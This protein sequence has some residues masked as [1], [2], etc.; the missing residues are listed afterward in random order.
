MIRWILGGTG[1]LIVLFAGAT[2]AAGVDVSQTA[3]AQ[4][5]GGGGLLMPVAA[6]A[7]SQGFGCTPYAFEPANPA[8][9]SGH[10]HSGIDLTSAAGMPVHATLGGVATVTAS[11]L[12][13]GLHVVVDHGG[14]LSSLYGHLSEVD[15]V[16]GA[17]V[18]AGAVIGRVGS[19]GNSTGPHLH[20]EIRRD[21]I[22]EDPAIDI[23]LR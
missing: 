19:T 12:G 3:A 10:W 6:A 4:P 22:P 8:C 23:P 7:V 1:V 5:G 14:G 13:Y 21:N 18:D 2:G 11:A 20:F 15:V 17:L 9:A 16:T